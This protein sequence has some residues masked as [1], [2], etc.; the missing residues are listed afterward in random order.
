MAAAAAVREES[1]RNEE[2]RRQKNTENEALWEAQRAER[3]ADRAQRLV[4]ERARGGEDPDEVRLRVWEVQDED[5]EGSAED[6]AQ[7]VVPV[8]GNVTVTIT[9]GAAPM[10]D[11]GSKME[12]PAP[13]VADAQPNMDAAATDL[14]P[15]GAG[16]AGDVAGGT[17]PPGPGV[18]IVRK[19]GLRDIL[20][21]IKK[22]R[23]Q[24][25]AAG[26][27]ESSHQRR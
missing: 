22:M 23:A 16:D 1:R 25:I 26:E 11:D 4:D 24:Q 2:E 15:G 8:N 27:S 3:G 14:E 9:D 18:T 6:A 12:A 21:Q 20:G 7:K 10:I 5:Q 13:A 17:R 19:P